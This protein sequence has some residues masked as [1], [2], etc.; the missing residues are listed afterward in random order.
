M[1]ESRNA[2]EAPLEQRSHADLVR[3]VGE[4]RQMVRETSVFA[5]RQS[6]VADACVQIEISR[7]RQAGRAGDAM[8]D[9]MDAIKA[10]NTDQAV[11]RLEA[12]YKELTETGKRIKQA[13]RNNPALR[14]D[15][16]NG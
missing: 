12:A 6:Q 15:T 11:E 9:A 14:R 5:E 4:M 2:P 8:I 10:G 3:L 13:I 1:A 16:R 7:D